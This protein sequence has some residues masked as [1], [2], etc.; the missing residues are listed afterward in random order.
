MTDNEVSS[1]GAKT[2][3]RIAKLASDA[4]VYAVQQ[5]SDH[6]NGLAQQVLRDFTNHVSDEVQGMFGNIYSTLA[7]HEDTPDEMRSLFTELAHGQGQGVGWLGGS[8]A[9]TA[10]SAS[11]FDFVNNLM[12]P[13]VHRLIAAL[14]N[15][16][17]SPDIVAQ[18]EV[19][20]IFID[21][22]PGTYQLEHRGNGL[23][24]ARYEVLKQLAIRKLS[25]NQIQDAV[26][27]GLMTG[28]EGQT[29][30][31]RDGY[32]ARDA[33]RLI[34]ARAWIPSPQE[35]AAME[36]RDIVNA[37]E[38]HQLGALYGA[39]DDMIDKLIQLVGEPLGPQ[40]LAEAF[41]RG[42]IGRDRFERG[43]IQG[44]L[45]KEWFDVLEK[46]SISRM[47]TVDAA[48]AVNQGHMSLE[49]AQDVA[50][51]NGLDDND[52]A[53]LIQIAGAPPGVDFI[54]EALNRGIIDEATFT[55]A[56]LESRI[57]N[58]YVQLFLQM[59]T[60][61]IPQETVRLL[62][63]N[64]VYP[65]EKAL[66]TLL[67]HGFTQ[68]DSEALLALENTRQDGGARELTRAQIVD[69]YEVRALPRDA[70]QEMLV[71]LGYDE[72]NAATLLDLADFKH[73]QTFVNSAITRV[74]SA[75]ITGKIDAANAGAQLDG[76]LVPTEQQDELFAI[77]NIER[78]TITKTLTPAQVRQA[79]KKNLISPQD[80][81]DRLTAAGYALDDAELFLQ[82][83][84]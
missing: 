14:P 80:G 8:I 16:F 34:K 24:D 5:L 59:R 29:E 17:L 70:A 50:T 20:G 66:Q 64:G 27:R 65:R 47:S 78:T 22:D 77:W 62:Y 56:F 55:G 2:G 26:N 46:L 63:R 35:I 31:E 58:K 42:F 15:S 79:V 12:A 40:S 49:Q 33:A 21:N 32:T 23:D 13:V 9:G 67:W 44:P 57:K 43:I 11:L 1:L 75:Y 10:A 81:I 61:I 25:A 37:S 71:S 3:G 4:V 74:K 41:R 69:L 60:R 84:T 83:T 48:D 51:A 54:T 28:M 82:L 45:R 73:L 30:L 39:D 72:T 7:Q 36:E 68:E 52:F 18:A 53:T 38:A 76:L 6:K 19:R